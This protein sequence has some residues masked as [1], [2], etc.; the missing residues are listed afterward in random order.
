MLVE[1]LHFMDKY[2]FGEGAEHGTR[3]ACA[4]KDSSPFQSAI[5]KY[6]WFLHSAS[7][8]QGEDE[9]DKNVS[10]LALFVDDPLFRVGFA[11]HQPAVMPPCCAVGSGASFPQSEQ[12][13]GCINFEYSNILNYGKNIAGSKTF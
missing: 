7:N 11:K 6:A 9:N 2:V 12:I 1:I 13:A 5:L 4:P 10:L 3:G 8:I